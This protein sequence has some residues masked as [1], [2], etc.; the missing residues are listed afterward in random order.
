LG[1]QHLSAAIDS[2]DTASQFCLQKA[3]FYMMDTIVTYQA[4]L[5]L[6]NPESLDT[7]GIRLAHENDIE[8]LADISAECFGNRLQNINRFNSDPAFSPQKVRQLYADWLR[9]LFKHHLADQVLVADDK[10]QAVGFIGVKLPSAT[11]L[12]AGL[13]VGRVPLNAVH[14]DFHRRG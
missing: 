2:N 14:P 10:G 13:N 11:Q 9:N 1:L 4:Q 8:T 12:R 7:F 6:M 3:G 5:P